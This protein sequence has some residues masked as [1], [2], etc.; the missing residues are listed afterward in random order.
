MIIILLFCRRVDSGR[1]G[2]LTEHSIGA[3]SDSEVGNFNINGKTNLQTSMHESLS[4]VAVANQISFDSDFD[5]KKKRKYQ[6][7]EEVYF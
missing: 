1:I 5:K 4:P 3:F 7:L 2:G 6:L